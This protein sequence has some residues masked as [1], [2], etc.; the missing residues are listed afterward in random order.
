MLDNHYLW[1]ISQ[2]IVCKSFYG[3]MYCI[4]HSLSTRFTIKVVDFLRLDAYSTR[5]SYKRA[6][7]RE[8]YVLHGQTRISL[9][10]FL[11]PYFCGLSSGALV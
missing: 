11:Q 2:Y 10:A 1:S 5:L 6:D 3:R 7:H 4:Y 8:A 9:L